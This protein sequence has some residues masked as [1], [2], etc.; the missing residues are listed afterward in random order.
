MPIAPED[1]AF[2]A[3]AVP[4]GPH[5]R[6]IGVLL[7]H[8]FTGGPS[9]LRA[10]AEYL[11][12]HGF[13]VSVPRLPGHGTRWEELNQT[14]YEDWY[15]E[16]DR[17]FEKLQTECDQVFVTGLSMGGCLA[18]H[19]AVEKGREL[20]G[21]VLVNPSVSSARRNLLLLPLM[22]H[23]VPAS[24][25]IGSDVKKPGVVER[26]YP[27]TP[28]KAAH[29]FL[30]NL[31]DVRER[32]PEVTQPLLLFRSRVDHV[33]DPSSARIILSSVSSRDLEERVLEDSYHVAT[34]DNDAPAIFAASA[35]FIRRV[36]EQSRPAPTAPGP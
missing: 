25:G 26:A 33:V 14:T 23:L 13:A 20:V 11:S 8:G 34:L 10:W 18:L 17:A 22:K 1:E 3:R 21:L 30:T 9:S 24:R 19:L 2:A 29:S 6:R 15:A 16:V 35:E 4:F 28:L 27:K 36:A 31:K 7:C 32:L 5:G 12:G